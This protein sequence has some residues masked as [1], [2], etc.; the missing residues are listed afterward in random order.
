M[1][2]SDPEALSSG[3]PTA[4]K[5]CCVYLPD[6]TASLAPAR[7]SVSLRDMLSSLCEKRGFP[8]QDVILYQ[9]GK[10]KVSPA[11]YLPSVIHLTSDF[12][13]MTPQDL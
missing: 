7:P 4:D 3:S 6:G 10:D 2:I 5:Y 11:T 13:I 12:S 8:L 1:A 9:H